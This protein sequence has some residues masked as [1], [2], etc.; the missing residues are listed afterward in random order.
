MGGLLQFLP[1]LVFAFVVISIIRNA[2]KVA[3]KMAE[4]TATS[5]SP[6]NFDPT[7]AERTRRI[8]EEIRRKIAERRGTVAPAEP[9]RRIEPVAER[10][11]EPENSPAEPPPISSTEAVLERQQQLADQ[12]RALEA[13]RLMEQRKAAAVAVTAR[14]ETERAA[15]VVAMR[16]ALRADLRN[17]PTARRAMLLR[18]IL[19]R[20]VALR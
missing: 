9:V 14:N 11:A 17:P 7:E 6:A 20:P 8:Q 15:A 12:M 10:T 16:G 19:G 1:F 2:V 3:R 4:P 5:R 18:E 13:A